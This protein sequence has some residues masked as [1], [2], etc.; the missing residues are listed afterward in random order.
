MESLKRKE[1]EEFPDEIILDIL[2]YLPLKDLHRFK[3]LNRKLWNTLLLH[4]DFR[5]LRIIR[6]LSRP[7]PY[8]CIGMDFVPSIQAVKLLSVVVVHQHDDDD[9]RSLA[10]QVLH[11]G[12]DGN[13]NYCWK[14]VDVPD[15]CPQNSKRKK[16]QVFLGEGRSVAHCI[17]QDDDDIDVDTEVDILDMENDGYIDWNGHLSFAEIVKDELHVLVLQDYKRLKWAQTKQIIRLMPSFLQRI[18]VTDTAV[19]VHKYLLFFVRRNKIAGGTSYF[20]SY[21][22]HTGKLTTR[23]LHSSEAIVPS[24]ITT[25]LARRP[26]I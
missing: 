10:Y 9:H 20:C 14:S 25:R 17:S 8:L 23:Q 21:H 5:L 7:T 1:Q 18:D 15:Q 2:S 26:P 4:P 12:C 24:L 16:I 19:C 22:I 6:I 11:V 3:F 13:T